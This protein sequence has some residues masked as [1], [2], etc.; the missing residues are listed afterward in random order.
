MKKTSLDLNRLDV[1]TFETTADLSA[2][3]GREGRGTACWELVRQRS[4]EQPGPR[5]LRCRDLRRLTPPHYNPTP[6][7]RTIRGGGV[8]VQGAVSSAA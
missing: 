8:R 7:L 4:H 6:P 2:A 5:Q 1:Q 3:L